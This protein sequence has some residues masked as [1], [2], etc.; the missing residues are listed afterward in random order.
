MRILFV[1]D[2]VGRPGRRILTERL[3]AIVSARK[4]DLVIANCE[5][6]AAGFGVTPDLADSLLEAN[7]HV[8][9]SGNHIWDKRAIFDYF[10]T[11]PRL[12]R[13]A[14]YP[15][16]PGKGLYVGSTPDG[17][18]YAVLNLQ[19]R[20]YLP[21][22]E[23]PFRT[24]DAMLASLDSD[25]RV[26]FVD[27]HAE[28]TS[29]KIAFGWYVD[30]RVSAMVGTHTHVPTADERILPGGTAYI[31]D[32]GMT[33]PH[34]SVI[35]MDKEGSLRRFLTGLPARFEPA[36]NDVRLNAVIVD[37]DETTGRALSIERYVCR[38]DS[39]RHQRDLRE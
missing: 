3:D 39:E 21:A 33:G 18:R 25:V 6:A 28:V 13:P 36:L 32:V 38:E 37:V 16:A 4:P 22:I 27:F 10:P 34:D 1:G 30:G 12:L 26:R 19:G 29:E 35:G 7:V 9:T 31:T 11:Q 23:C 20:T 2:I 24:V 14:N 8:L 17:V 5:N 15:N